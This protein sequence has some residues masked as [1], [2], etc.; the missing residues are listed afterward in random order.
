MAIQGISANTDPYL[1]STQS[2]TSALSSEFKSLV[3]ALQSGDLKSAQD[4]FSQIQSSQGTSGIGASGTQSQISSDFDALG[5]ALQ[6]GNADAAKDALN[7]LTQD[8]QSTGKVHHHHHHG[9]KPP[10]RSHHIL[11]SCEQYYHH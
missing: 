10:T 5:K 1:P 9:G 3:N 7:K 4:A 8:M 6:S 11:D 2:N